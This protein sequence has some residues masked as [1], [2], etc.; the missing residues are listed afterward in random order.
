MAK[1][2]LQLISALKQQHIYSLN[3]AALFKN[4]SSLSC[5]IMDRIL[6]STTKIFCF[7][8]L[9]LNLSGFKRLPAIV[10]AP[11][12]DIDTTFPTSKGIFLPVENIETS[13]Y[14]M[15]AVIIHAM[16][17][18]A[19]PMSAAETA[20]YFVCLVPYDTKGYRNYS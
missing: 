18:L 5:S 13:P 16:S 1:A 12:V 6:S 19:R 10:I 20:R 8:T 11:P 9:K 2:R 14:R 17:P 3:L 7:I 15:S 4:L